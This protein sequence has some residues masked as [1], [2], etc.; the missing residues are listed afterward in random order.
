MSFLAHILRMFTGTNDRTS[1]SGLQTIRIEDVG[2]YQGRDQRGVGESNARPIMEIPMLAGQNQRT[3]SD[4]NYT[5]DET[6]H[7]WILKTPV[8]HPNPR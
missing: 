7:T 6:S 5:Q 2:A 3:R 4:S 1:A 8:E